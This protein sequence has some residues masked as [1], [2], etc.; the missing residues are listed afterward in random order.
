MDD[1]ATGTSTAQDLMVYRA[2]PSHL[3]NTDELLQ[4]GLAL[5][6]ELDRLMES[7]SAD[8]SSLST[9][10][11]LNLEMD[12]PFSLFQEDNTVLQP[13]SKPRAIQ[14]SSLRS[15]KAR[16]VESGSAAWARVWLQRGLSKLKQGNYQGAR[17]NFERA[18][19]KSS[20]SVSA[21]NGLGIAQYR[22]ANFIDAIHA[23]R[24]AI[25][26]E[27]LAAGHY[28][29][30][31]AALYQMGDF[32]NAV[33][34]FQK[35]ARLAPREVH[36]YYGLGVSLMQRQQYSQAIAAFRRGVALDDQH[37]ACYYGMGYVSY[38]L[39]ELPAAIAALGKAKQRNPQYARRYEAFL[40]HCLEQDD[41][42]AR[43]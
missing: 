36:A 29:N 27:P 26:L 39:G 15:S 22:L 31:G 34:M 24:Q 1:G 23:F 7:E 35:A 12:A 30:L 40:K 32:S 43:N 19:E 28:S 38:R 16:T 33:A 13:E 20:R 8:R 18:L 4:Q 17:D 21:L 9:L 2:D 6:D 14:V 41:L 11:P 42:S 3:I 37:A 10:S 25:D 5:A